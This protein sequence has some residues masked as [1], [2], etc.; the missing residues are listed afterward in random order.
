VHFARSGDRSQTWKLKQK[1]EFRNW[2]ESAQFFRRSFDKLK[3][4]LRFKKISE[5]LGGI[6][7]PETEWKSVKSSK[8]VFWI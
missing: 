3:L 4:S 2:K 6:Q 7:P 1:N 8:R 5:I